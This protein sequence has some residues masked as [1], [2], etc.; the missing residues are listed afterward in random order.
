MPQDRADFRP[1]LEGL[2]GLAILLVV[3]FHAEVAGLAGGFVGVDVFFVLSGFFIT[4]L[5]VREYANE[6]TVDV[7][8]FYGRRA[9]R[10][11]PPLFL[12]LL[13]TLAAVMWLW[14]PIDRAEIASSA[15][16]V[17]LS[18]GN[19]AFASNA[20]DYF[21]SRENPLLHTWSLGVEEQFY[22]VWAP[23]VLVVALLAERRRAAVGGERDAGLAKG[24][25]A[26]F[27]V[28]GVASLA[29]CI[30]L[31]RT[32]QPWAFFG[33]ATRLWE[34]ALG[35]ALAVTID[36]RAGAHAFGTVLQVAG[37]VAIGVAVA[38]YDRITPYPGTAALLPAL[39]AVALVL[40][41]R[42]APESVVSRA[43]GAR[44][45]RWLGRLSY[46]WYLWHWPLVGLGAVLHPDLG[47][48]GRLA[49][50]AAA[51]GLAWVTYTFVERSARDGQLARI[52]THWLPG[53]AL[54]AS[55]GAA[56]V[57]HGA[58]R[59]AERQASRPD[60][61]AFA[62]ARDDRMRHECWASADRAAVGPCVFGDTSSRTTV[63]LFG[64]SHAEHWLGA[65]DRV[66][67]ERGW[68]IALMVMGGCPVADM[69]EQGGT[70]A[71]R[72][73]A[74]AR[75]REATIQR[76]IAMRPTAAVLSSWDHYVPMKGRP[77]P[78]QVSSDVW[79]QGL[80]RTY[81]RLAGAGIPIAV[82]RGTPRTWF[83]VPACLSRRAASLPFA[84]EC[85]YDRA[86]S[87]S[88][89][90]ASAQTA[91]ARGLRVRIVDMNDQI[92]ATPRCGVVRNG[93]IVFTDDNHL[94]A[95]FSRSVAPVFGARLAAALGELGARLP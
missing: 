89:V 84:G 41:G 71:K 91:A 12:V 69:P 10:L 64:D 49:W 75:H 26:G 55:V 25:L 79:E 45:L 40:G 36:R 73:S 4:G 94:T 90:A 65:L 88:E 92:C 38:T 23:L 2:R 86:A 32:A 28:L 29:G 54:A 13:A 66:G 8:A 27:A 76:I 31:T 18:W 63:V 53:A 52:P 20:V 43:L 72:S 93:A 3:L 11:L 15:R 59:V 39:G 87:L 81:T 16:A 58:T 82:V 60:Q 57:A 46:A 14:A 68:R 7:P 35:G 5:L 77:T 30:W 42:V 21:G 56:L 6:G 24:L 33:T 22:L 78:W 48:G 50:S 44:G 19:V 1:D 85:T 17:A 83:D 47:V 51:L 95:S 9:L 37:L 34:F 74:C 61:R 62:A 67:R 80:R 70:R